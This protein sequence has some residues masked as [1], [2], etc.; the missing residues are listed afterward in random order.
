MP[1][2]F[3]FGTVVPC[4]RS[5]QEYVAMFDLSPENLDSRILDC[6]SGPASFNAEMARRGSRLISC[7]PLYL[8]TAVAISR[9]IDET[10]PEMIQSMEAGKAR[11]VWRHLG[12]PLQVGETRMAAMRLFLEDYEVGRAKGRYIA[13]ELPKLPFGSE[14]FD[15]V[16]SSHLLFL[17]T[18]QLSLEVHLQSIQEML[19]VARQVR[20]FPLLDLQ[21]Q[22]SMHLGPAPAELGRQGLRPRIQEVGYEFQRGGNQMLVVTRNEGVC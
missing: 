14:E 15:L 12:S 2:A 13:A 11:F 10:Y 21:G 20:I 8:Y 6:G 5:M 22:T 18:D 1:M 19:R 4:G 17:Y 3:D 16:F 7:D 9:R